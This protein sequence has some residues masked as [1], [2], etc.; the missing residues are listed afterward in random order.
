MSRASLKD[1]T[2]A[3]VRWT[4]LAR[5][6]REVFA[7]GTTVALAHLIVPSAFGR[8]AVA[9]SLLPLA[10]ILTYEGFASVLVQRPELDE[11]QVRSASLLSVVS[12]LMLSL[13]TFALARP[14]GGAVFGEDTAAL[15]QMASPIFFMAS[16]AAVPRALLSRRLDFRAIGVS[17]VA[18]LLAN[19]AVSLGLAI[20]G[21]NGQALIAGALAQ[22]LVISVTLTR[23]APPPRPAWRGRRT[24]REIVSFGL[25]AA[26]AGLVHVLFSNVDYIVVAARLSAAEAGF[27]WRAFQLGAVYQDKLSSVMMQLAFP[28]YSR[29]TSREE[30]AALHQRAARVHAAVIFPFLALLVVLAPTLVP[31]AFGEIWTPAVVPT[32]ILAV[33]GMAAAVLAGYPQ[34]LLALGEPRAL[35]RFNV[36]KLFVYGGGV[37]LAVNGG[38]TLLAVVVAALYAAIVFSA[39]KFMLGPRLGIPIL[40]IAAELVPALV[41]CLGLWAVTIPLNAALSGHVP[42]AVLILGVGLVGL[43]THAAVLRL[44]FHTVWADLFALASRVV[45]MPSLPR[46]FRSR[47]IADAGSSAG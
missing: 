36:I 42:V 19:C 35:L 13:L 6:I 45:P 25:P 3:G 22:T 14:V 46:R 39:Y 12:G 26:L 40:H 29:T 9:L 1:A 10:T 33:A 41:G 30:L 11:D 20:Y 5:V 15:L 27:Y 8:A 2:I 43:A 18:G 23:A 16:V 32:Q 21:V 4:M 31:W 24:Q 38:V 7:M 17:D 34:V 28:I 44:L 37:L 47:A